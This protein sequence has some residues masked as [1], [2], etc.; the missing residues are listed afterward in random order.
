MTA[1]TVDSICLNGTT[2]GATLTS[3][4]DLITLAS[5]SVTIAGDLTIS[6]DD[7]TM[8]TNTSGHIL[9]ADGT[10]C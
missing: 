2:I 4:T 5:G 10:N 9:V 3:D 8:G 1:L 6:G 7:L